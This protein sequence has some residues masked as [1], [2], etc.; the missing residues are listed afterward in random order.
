MDSQTFST[1]MGGQWASTSLVVSG[2]RLGSYWLPYSPELI[3]YSSTGEIVD[4]VYEELYKDDETV[5]PEN[6]PNII[7]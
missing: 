3:G 7:E 1:A 5:P 4:F 2:D 6:Y